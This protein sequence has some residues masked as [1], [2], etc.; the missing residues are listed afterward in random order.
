LFVDELDQV[1]V[2]L[3]APWATADNY[4]PTHPFPAI[5]EVAVAISSAGSS[6]AS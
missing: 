3:V 1:L 5:D 6:N 2:D 4:N